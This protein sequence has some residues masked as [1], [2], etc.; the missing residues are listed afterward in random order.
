VKED[1][2][3]V[4]AK[5]YLSIHCRK[6][7]DVHMPD[8]IFSKA[9]FRGFMLSRSSLLSNIDIGRQVLCFS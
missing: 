5:V 8:T 3:C 9:C 2:S 4:L 7:L 1:V 6:R